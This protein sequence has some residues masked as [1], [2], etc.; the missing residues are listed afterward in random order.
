M[1]QRRI[2]EEHIFPVLPICISDLVGEA[3]KS[4]DLSLTEIRLRSK[5]QPLL[6][7]DKKEVFLEGYICT[8]S[9][10]LY[11]VQRM[12]KYSLYA[13][14]QD[15]KMGFITIDGGHR[16]GITGQV[17]HEEGNITTIQHIG[18]INIRIAR[19]VYGCAKTIFR[20]LLDIDN[21]IYNTLIIAPPR[22]GKTTVLRDLIR[23]LSSG[24]QNF[25]GVQVGVVDERSEIAAC[26]HGV[27]TVNLGPRV[28]VMDACPKAKGML[29]LIRSMAPTVIA[30]D[31]L[32]REEDAYAIKEAL[33]AGISVITTIH[34]RDIAE[35][36]ERPYIGE[37]IKQGYFK[38]YII[39][40]PYPKVGT[41]K[42]VI[43]AKT[44]KNIY[45]HVVHDEL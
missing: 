11:T 44:N 30:T 20:Y 45:E 22:S 34:G 31:E 27:P 12:S 19:E 36:A 5:Q 9:D 41:I 35:I 15:L 8:Q 24:Y 39:L 18:S 37:I 25:Q 3:I 13:Y 10:L 43:D 21:A 2:V 6:V 7:F 38:R 14:E 23:I 33:T 4:T 16:V 28:D 32:G 17:I 40:T 29:M 1:Q 42:M 26:Q